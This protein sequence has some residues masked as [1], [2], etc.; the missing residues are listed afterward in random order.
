MQ[1]NSSSVVDM[2]RVTIYIHK[3]LCSLVQYEPHGR[4]TKTLNLIERS[5]HAQAE[6]RL[7]EMNSGPLRLASGVSLMRNYYSYGGNSIQ[8]PICRSKLL[9]LGV[10]VGMQPAIEYWLELGVYVVFRYNGVRS[11]FIYLDGQ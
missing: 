5:L 7:I 11:C 6:R 2:N 1:N 3:G 4:N 9:F 8:I 10:L